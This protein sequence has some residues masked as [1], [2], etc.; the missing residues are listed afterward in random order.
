VRVHDGDNVIKTILTHAL[1]NREGSIC[2]VNISTNE[3]FIMDPRDIA[4]T[5]QLIQEFD[6]AQ[7]FYI[8]L[9]AGLKINNPTKNRPILRLL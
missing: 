8:G 9:F 1:K 4:L 5:E 6:A 7:A 2:F 3:K